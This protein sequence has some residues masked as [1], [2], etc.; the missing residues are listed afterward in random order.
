MPAPSGSR[1]EPLRAA[2]DLGRVIERS[3]E[4]PASLRVWAHTLLAEL[5]ELGGDEALAEA[6]YRA[7]LAV[8]ERDSYLLGAYGDFLLDRGRYD[9]VR[10]LLAEETRIDAL[11]LRLTLAEQALG[12]PRAADH[13]ADLA[14]RFDASRR[15][16]DSRH[17]REE[18]RF[19]LHI[20]NDPQRALGLALDN[21]QE[22]KE[23]S[24][25]R[26]VLEAALAA[27]APDHAGSVADWL[28]ESGLADARITPLLRRLKEGSV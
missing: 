16:G 19:T 25:A 2:A 14:A 9:Q 3:A 26:L 11:L 4:A 28:A 17:D 24:D 23:P 1:G 18:T 12:D 7:A 20:L 13:A 22:Q 8:G 21:W 5:G 15:R 27:E 10:R 6:S